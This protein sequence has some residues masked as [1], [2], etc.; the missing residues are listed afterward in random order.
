MRGFG[1]LFG[2]ARTSARVCGWRACEI[3]MPIARQMA[4]SAMTLP[5]ADQLLSP[6]AE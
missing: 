6:T 1:R 2:M 3:V 4:N 5:E